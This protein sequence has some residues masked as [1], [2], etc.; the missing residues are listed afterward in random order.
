MSQSLKKW[1]EFLLDPTFGFRFLVGFSGTCYIDN[2]YFTDVIYRYSL[3]EAVEQGFAKSIEYVREDTSDSQDEKFQKIYDNH[4]QHKNYQYRKVKPLTILVTKDI[5]D[6]K[7]LTEDLI[8]F[9]ADKE[10]ISKEEAEKKVLIVTSANE[11]QA[12]TRELAHVDRKDNP[13]EWITSVSMLTEGWD[14]QNVFQ[15]VPHEERAFNSKL[16]IAQVLG[17]GLRVPDAYKG[18]KPEVIVF[19][20]DAWSSR[21]K[22]LVDEVMEVE[23]R[24]VSYPIEKSANYHF[25]LH[26][27]DYTK[28]QV[29]EEY[30]QTKEYEFGKDP[31]KLISQAPAL[32]RETTYE[33]VVSGDHRTK[34]TLVKYRMSTIEEVAEAIHYRFASIDLENEGET[35]YADKYSL[36]WLK[37]LI[38]ESLLRVGEN[39][40]QISEEN[41]Q[42]LYAAFGTLHRSTNQRVRYKITPAAIK[43]INT[44]ERPQNS[45]G[46]GSIRKGFVTVFADEHSLET[47]DEEALK[48][49]NE[50]RDDETL[51]R[52]AF[53][54]VNNSYLF[55]T[56][57]NVVLADHK[58]EREF[59]RH[60][61]KPENSKAIEAWIKSV[62]QKFYDIEYSWR[63]GEHPIRGY[64]NPDF[65]IKKGDDILVIEIKGDEEIQDPSLENKGKY[66]DGKKHFE[67]V[68]KQQSESHYFFHF[69]APKDYDLF[70][71]SLRDGNYA[72][73]VSRLDDALD[74]NLE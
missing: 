60:L 4:L 44:T 20:H 57:L 1:K 42:R 9:L 59:V 37:R 7:R 19:N 25:I 8:A 49:L 2:E 41:R 35:N 12:N 40:N 33:R 31:I 13:R 51:P 63:K 69:L 66:R 67:T 3:S 53:D 23:K 72:T 46:V 43:K 11:H 5:A 24:V 29:I 50:I 18:E 36:D 47:N 48:L 62:D 32:E 30:P 27:L 34:K 52:S 45:A 61:I 39:E 16:L 21:I 10:G 55:K 74:I 26:H 71:R 54:F 6:C 58:P 22:H 28:T 56:P 68:N 14:V 65:F 64:F 70:F 17:R 15:I 38:K 73:F